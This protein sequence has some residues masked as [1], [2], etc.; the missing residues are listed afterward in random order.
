MLLTFMLGGLAWSEP[1]RAAS[2]MDEGYE[3]YERGDTDLA[4]LIW[5]ELALDGNATAQ[6]NLGQLYRLGK[7]VEQNDAE[8]VK[9][10]IMAARNGSEIASVTLVQMEQDGRASKA[11]VAAA[12]PGREG[13]LEDSLTTMAQGKPA[14]S[15]PPPKAPARTTQPAASVAMVTPAAAPKPQPQPQSQ[16]KP[17]PAAAP[18]RT[19]STAPQTIR[20]PTV[21]PTAEPV[22][23]TVLD[24]EPAIAAAATHVARPAP[25]AAAASSATV[26]SVYQSAPATA[27]PAKASAPA[28][29]PSP[30]PSPQPARDPAPVTAPSPTA[31]VAMATPAAAP[32]APTKAPAKPAATAKPAPR[33]VA[34]PATPPTPRARIKPLPRGA[35]VIQLLASANKT[36]LDNYARQNLRGVRAEQNILFTRRGPKTE[37]LLMLGPYIS[38]VAANRAVNRL[39]ATVRKG[40]PW[41]GGQPWVRTTDSVM[42]IAH[43][44]SE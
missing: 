9:W 31:V 4:I 32:A 19:S 1:G 27:P 29:Q 5:Q 36:A 6:L 18:A 28:P 13:T 17:A 10:Y 25:P 22:P 30:Q 12:F 11:D 40:M 24:A 26:A 39:P 33:A 35:Y 15:T 16:Q 23:E 42:R 43:Y 44:A 14:T 7:G 38:E 2:T 21:E 3:A 41:A 34:A 20:L 37:Y 8:A